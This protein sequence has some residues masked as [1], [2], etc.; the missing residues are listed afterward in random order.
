MD[1]APAS[2]PQ[3]PV[4]PDRSARVSVVLEPRTLVP[5]VLRNVSGVSAAVV[6]VSWGTAMLSDGDRGAATVQALVVVALL[7]VLP[8]VV[9][10]WCERFLYAVDEAGVDRLAPKEQRIELAELTGVRLTM[11]SVRGGLPTRR[12]VVLTAGPQ[13]RRVH[14]RVSEMFVADLGP[15][16]VRLDREVQRRPE[17]LAAHQHPLF[18]E[19]VARASR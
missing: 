5:R 10:W 11:D 6:L 4:P 2:Q 8:L 3:P 1:N 17:L 7:L 12:A 9:A 18:A 15:L 19:L 13:H 16:L 14:L